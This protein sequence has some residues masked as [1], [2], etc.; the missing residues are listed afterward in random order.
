MGP[1]PPSGP[2]VEVPGH[3]VGG[4]H[5]ALVLL[6]LLPDPLHLLPK[7]PGFRSKGLGFSSFIWGPNHVPLDRYPSYFSF[8]GILQGHPLRGT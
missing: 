8:C 7:Q 2:S 3:I 1:P 5:E 6:Q 4:A